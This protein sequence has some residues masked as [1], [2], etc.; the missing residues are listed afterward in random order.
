MKGRL[1]LMQLLVGVNE[2][3]K[4]GCL[5]LGCSCC[6]DSLVFTSNFMMTPWLF[7]VESLYCICSESPLIKYPRCWSEKNK[8]RAAAKVHLK[9]HG[10][11]FCTSYKNCRSFLRATNVTICISNSG[12]R[13]ISSFPSIFLW[14]FQLVWL[15]LDV[16]EEE[17]YRSQFAKCQESFIT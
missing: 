15:R 9:G 16:E 5:G 14:Q 4:F 7:L 6:F 17:Y 13:M 1:S 3:H 12:Y 2:L 11:R 8:Q 10:I